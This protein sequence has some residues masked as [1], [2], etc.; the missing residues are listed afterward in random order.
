MSRPGTQ[1]LNLSSGKTAPFRS[2]PSQSCAIFISI[3]F[4]A[5]Q[6]VSG[7]SGPEKSALKQILDNFQ[8][9][10]SVAPWE[11]TD[12]EGNYFGRS[13]N[14]SFADLCQVDGYDYYGVFCKNRQV[15]GLRVYVTSCQAMI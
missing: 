13:W 5:F 12:R 4:I 1:T 6:I 10:E 14:D 2:K 3:L 8:D 7:L 9:L 15:V 11:T